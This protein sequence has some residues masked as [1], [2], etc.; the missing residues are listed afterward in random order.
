MTYEFSHQRAGFGRSY[1]RHGRQVTIPIMCPMRW[2]TVTTWTAPW[3]PPN[4]FCK[5]KSANFL[6][7]NQLLTCQIPQEIFRIGTLG[8]GSRQSGFRW[9]FGD[10]TIHT[11]EDL[12]VASSHSQLL[13]IM[14]TY[15]LLSEIRL[16]IPYYCLIADEMVSVQGQHM[17]IAQK[18]PLLRLAQ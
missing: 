7:R 3:R 1:A 2:T 17:K 13:T 18:T 6:P 16:T 5:S 4:P 11:L 15:L 10:T 14:C 9:R 12:M 8:I